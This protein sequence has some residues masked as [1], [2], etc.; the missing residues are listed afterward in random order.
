MI[1]ETNVMIVEMLKKIKV[2]SYLL[3]EVIF[4]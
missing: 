3:N 4:F 2:M 1:S